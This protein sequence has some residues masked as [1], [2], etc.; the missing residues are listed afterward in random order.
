MH[1]YQISWDYELDD[2]AKNKDLRLVNKIA[3]H[4]KNKYLKN[5]NMFNDFEVNCIILSNTKLGVY[6]SG[7]SSRPVIG[8][9]LGN[10]KIACEEYFVDFEVALKTTIYH[11]LAHA[12]Q[13][14]KEQELNEIQ[15]ENFA[16]KLLNN[17][18]ITI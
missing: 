7:T 1:D 5:L 15:A 9:D 8:I 16:N 14:Y 12:M 11:E 3:N 2:Y 13:E 17:K 4:F 6:C 18:L 10:L